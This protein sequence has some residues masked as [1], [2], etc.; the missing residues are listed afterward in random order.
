MQ[1]NNRWQTIKTCEKPKLIIQR[2][3]SARTKE[4]LRLSRQK[5]RLATGKVTCHSQLN[6]HL[7][8]MGIISDPTC[9]Y[10]AEG[11]ETAAHFLYSRFVALRQDSGDMG[12]ILFTPFRS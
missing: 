12:K 6:R 4:L 8:V 9:N 10:C 1:A 11:L 2:Q 5:L 7:S 3:S